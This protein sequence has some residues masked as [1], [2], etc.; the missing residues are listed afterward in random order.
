MTESI[1]DWLERLDLGEYA[2]AFEENHLDL[3]LIVDLSDED[4]RDLGVA[5]MGHRKK[6]I[7]AIRS[8]L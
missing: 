2:E 7:R 5:S 4:L 1:R 8:H 3:N 6:L